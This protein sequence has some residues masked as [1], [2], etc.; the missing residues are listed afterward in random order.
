MRRRH[1]RIGREHLFHTHITRPHGV[2]DDVG[3]LDALISRAAIS[4]KAFTM[5]FATYMPPSL[6]E[7]AT[8]K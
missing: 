3:P 1:M 4:L 7:L 2:L 6:L 5:S 8:P